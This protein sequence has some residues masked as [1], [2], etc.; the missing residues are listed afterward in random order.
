M[1][2]S[3]LSAF[4]CLSVEYISTVQNAAVFQTVC[5]DLDFVIYRNGND[6]SNNT[7]CRSRVLIARKPRA[8]PRIWQPSLLIFFTV[9]LDGSDIRDCINYIEECIHRQYDKLLTLRLLCLLS[10]TSSGLL[11]RDYQSLKLQFLHSY[12]F[13]HLITFFNLKKV[14]SLCF[15]VVMICVWLL[16]FPADRW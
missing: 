4:F 2:P 3:N 5:N 1:Y 16:S 8:L 11:P 14:S 9:M 15:H 10:C 7:Q 12:G 13:E 6:F